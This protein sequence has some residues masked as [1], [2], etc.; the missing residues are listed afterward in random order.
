MRPPTIPFPALVQDFF[1][2][3]LVEQRGASARTI[4]SAAAAPL[5]IDRLRHE[6][7]EIQGAVHG[8]DT[9]PGRTPAGLHLDRRKLRRREHEDHSPA[10]RRRKPDGLSTGQAADSRR[11][12]RAR[13]NP[14]TDPNNWTRPHLATGLIK[15]ALSI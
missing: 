8:N 5:V 7:R 1:L 11:P 15:G 10:H 2:R 14:A 3:R 4:E 13:Q 12:Q 6:P 9:Y